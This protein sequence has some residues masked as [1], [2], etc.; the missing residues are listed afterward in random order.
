MTEAEI[1]KIVDDVIAEGPFQ[2]QWGSLMQAQIP[3]WYRQ[4]KLG[5]FIHWGVYSVPAKFNEW[6]SRNMYIKDS[7]E[8]NYHS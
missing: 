7:D 6:Y 3:L 2:P 8:Y 5:I 4:R 1:L